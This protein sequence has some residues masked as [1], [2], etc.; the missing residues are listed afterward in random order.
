MAT[1][2][3]IPA[4]CAY[5]T[6]LMEQAVPGALVADG[7]PANASVKRSTVLVGDIRGAKSNPVSKAGRKPRDERYDVDLVILYAPARGTAASARS[8]A[9]D[10]LDVLDDLI[11]ED[12]HL[13][14]MD[15]V[16]HV[17]LG[18]FTLEAGQ[19]NEGPI[20]VITQT[21]RVVARLN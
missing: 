9:V 8:G 5:L 2:S 3:T 6:A 16:E 15:G 1:T 12:V 20:C 11:A 4:V 21:V 7:R 14:D 17:T 13:G 19:G 10:I 18:D